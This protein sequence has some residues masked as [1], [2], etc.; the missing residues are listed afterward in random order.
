VTLPTRRELYGRLTKTQRTRRMIQDTLAG[1]GFAEAYNPSLVPREA[2]PDAVRLMEPLSSEQEVLRTWLLEGLIASARRNEEVG[3]EDVA[4]FEL[5][6]VYLPAGEQLPY[7]PWHVGGIVQ[8]G[9]ARAKGTVEALYAA[10]ALEPSFGPVDDIRG[11]GRGARTDEGWVLALRDPDLPGQWGAFELDVDALVARIPEIVVY[12][13]V[14]TY[15]PVRQ[16]LAFVVD[17]SV[18]AGELF[19]AAREAAAPEL[20]ELRFL[21]DYRGPPIPAGK[22]SIAFSVAFQSPERTLT[23]EDA[24]TL[25]QRVIDALERLFDAEL[26]A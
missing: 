18:P 3:N 21:S 10:L 19:A 6:H 8:G 2:D 24:A 22:K 9:F 1:F 12:K 23:D 17:E 15:P 13:D 5:A 11:R 7:E 16:E 14:I 4:L 20:R 25:R 26:R